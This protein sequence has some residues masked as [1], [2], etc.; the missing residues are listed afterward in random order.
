MG[1]G[2]RIRRRRISCVD[3]A[4]GGCQ[5]Q[6]CRWICH[7]ITKTRRIILSQSCNQVSEQTPGSSGHYI[8]M[9]FFGKCSLQKRVDCRNHH[10]R[11]PVSFQKAKPFFLPAQKTS[12]AAMCNFCVLV[13]KNIQIA[14]VEGEFFPGNLGQCNFPGAKKQT[15]QVNN[16]DCS[17]SIFVCLDLKSN[18]GGAKIGIRE[19]PT[20]YP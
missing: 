5:T 18:K 13:D 6:N 12:A 8:S 19:V 14:H 10:S 7:C 15:N 3:C 11:P 2:R 20:Q 17:H 9:V 4:S 1:V 16:G